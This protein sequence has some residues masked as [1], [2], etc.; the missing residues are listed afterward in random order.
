M[1]FAGFDDADFEVFA[2]PGFE[3]RMAAIRAGIQ[4]KL[5][6]IGVELAPRAAAAVG[7]DVFAHGAKHMRR[8]VNPP[9]DTWVALGP[10]RRGYKKHPHFKVAISGAC[11]RVL[12]EVGP[13]HAAKQRWRGAWR[14]SA[15]GALGRSLAKLEGLAWFKNEHDDDPA[16]ALA[17]LAAAEIAALADPLVEKQD[18]Q[19]VIGRRI[20]RA[21]ALAPKR[22]GRP[23]L[24]L[25]LATIEALAPAYEL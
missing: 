23:L 14:K 5:G 25:A 17:D 10:D 21:E 1:P 20:G 11:V 9:G 16:A 13:E 6:A 15:S 4:P 24:D 8:R 19:L 3:E 18:G 22:K 7:A 12:F 2:I